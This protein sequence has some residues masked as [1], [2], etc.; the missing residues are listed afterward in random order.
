MLHHLVPDE[1]SESWDVD[2]CGGCHGADWHV[3]EGRIICLL[4]L[5]AFDN[6]H[7]KLA[8][9][10][11]DWDQDVPIAKYHYDMIVRVFGPVAPASS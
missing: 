9:Q 4:A 1:M 3:E 11:H 8:L 2:S 7:V 6:R 5:T 10:Q